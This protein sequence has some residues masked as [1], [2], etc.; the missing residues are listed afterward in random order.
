MN[1]TGHSGFTALECPGS[2]L[3]YLVLG[4]PNGGGGGGWGGGGVC[5]G[6]PNLILLFTCYCLF[7][8]ASF[9][10]GPNKALDILASYTAGTKKAACI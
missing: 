3:C 2:I 4:P 9:V 6:P 7:R 10:L 1:V 8:G 5:H